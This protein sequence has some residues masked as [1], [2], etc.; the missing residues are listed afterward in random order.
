MNKTVKRKSIFVPL[1]SA[2]MVVAFSG[3]AL[4]VDLT[5]GASVWYAWW[6]FATKENYDNVS[7]D[8]KD[9]GFMYG[10]LVSLK[11]NETWSLSTRFMTGAFGYGEVTGYDYENDST[12]ISRE[13]TFKFD[14]DTIV[15]YSIN[16]MVRVFGGVKWMG[17]NWYSKNWYSSIE[18][19]PK[20][21]GYKSYESTVGPGLG[22]GF[23]IPLADSFYLMINLNGV[24]TVGTE[25]LVS[26]YYFYDPDRRNDSGPHVQIFDL[27]SWGGNGD[28]AFAYY[29]SSAKTTLSLGF[30]YQQLKVVGR[31]RKEYLDT[32]D[33]A[34]ERDTQDV[35]YGVTLSALYYFDM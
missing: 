17:Y 7:N 26:T 13:K 23:S 6:Q 34:M 15:T 24:Y 33:P 1:V 8:V 28:I 32:Q 20:Y 16:R 4:A 2:L 35:F 12:F 31:D 19:Y 27:V 22:V 9:N 29:F 5:V 10:P 21:I 18:G 30:R 14:S 25:E 11:F 3:A